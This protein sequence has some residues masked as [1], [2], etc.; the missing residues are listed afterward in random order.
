MFDVGPD[1][2]LWMLWNYDRPHR[3]LARYDGSGWAI[4]DEADGVRPWVADVRVAPDGSAWVSAT[5]P[6]E[7]RCRGLGRFDGESWVS[8]LRDGCIDSYDIAPDGAVWVMAR[9]LQ[10]EGRPGAYVITPEAVAASDQG[11][12]SSWI[13]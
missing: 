6:D 10:G 3:S 11:G 13:R 4:F 1:G 2:T 12:G 7:G 5:D 9:G 8:F